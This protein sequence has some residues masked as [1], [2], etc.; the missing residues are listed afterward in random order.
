MRSIIYIKGF[1]FLLKSV[2]DDSQKCKDGKKPLLVKSKLFIFLLQSSLQE[3][4]WWLSWKQLHCHALNVTFPL[5][6]D[7]TF[8]SLSN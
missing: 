6:K 3:Q 7:D 4:L 5:T 8:L 2:A 1:C